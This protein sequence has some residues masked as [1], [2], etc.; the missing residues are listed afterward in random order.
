MPIQVTCPSCLKRFQVSEKFAG[1]SGPCPNCKKPIRIPEKNEEVVI[2]VPDDGAPKD[3]TGKSVLK[4]LQRTETNVTRRGML[5][6][7]AAVLVAIGLALVI[8]FTTATGSEPAVWARVLAIVLLAPPLVWAGYS[9]VR[10]A[11]L[12]PY[13]ASQLWIRVAILSGIFAALWVLYAFLPSYLLDLESAAQMSFLWFGIVFC[14]MLGVGAFA[15]VATFELEFAGGLAHVGLY[16]IITLL[17]GVLAGVTFA[18]KPIEDRRGQPTVWLPPD[19]DHARLRSSPVAAVARLRSAP[20]AEVARLRSAPVAE[21]ARLRSAP[22]AEVA[23]LWSPSSAGTSC[24]LP[25]EPA[26]VA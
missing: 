11:E 15:S 19:R 1:K 8:R 16:L 10:D 12:A 14:L 17:L 22:V 26:D 5:I 21:V 4:P 18:G 6:T 23:R 24:R 3:R 7:A 25:C 13:V 20:V 9:F 2:H